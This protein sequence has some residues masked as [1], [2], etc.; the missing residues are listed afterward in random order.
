M[1]SSQGAFPLGQMPFAFRA[2]TALG[3]PSAETLWRTAATTFAAA[4]LSHGAIKDAKIKAW[5]AARAPLR[6]R[7]NVVNGLVFRAAIRAA[8]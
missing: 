2:A 7:V 6:T 5:K 4:L 1:P 8:L 3:P